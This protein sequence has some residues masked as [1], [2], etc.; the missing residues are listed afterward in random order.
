MRAWHPLR[1]NDSK[2]NVEIIRRD[3]EAFD[4]G[5]FATFLDDLHPEVVTWAHPRGDAGRYEG[6]EGV[7]R[8][9]TDWTESFE[10]FRQVAEEFR[11]ADDKVLVRVLHQGRG[12]GSG[13]PVEG[14][15]WLVHHMR[16]GKAYQVDLYDD[17]AEALEAA[18][19]RE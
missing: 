17:K 9:I 14:R 4:R 3:Y 13:I 15:Y 19:L 11:D 16:E 7:I 8:F 2:E 18:G 12:K 1:P 10:E 5:D 6:K